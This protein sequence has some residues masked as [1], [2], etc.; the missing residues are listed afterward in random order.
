MAWEL[1]GLCMEKEIMQ[2]RAIR[3]VRC[4]CLHGEWVRSRGRMH[5]ACMEE[6]DSHARKK[7]SGPRVKGSRPAAVGP[8]LLGLGFAAALT[9]P[10]DLDL[11]LTGLI[12]EGVGPW[13]WVR[14]KITT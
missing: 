13:A 10:A 12:L 5:E 4:G 7:L 2:G 14:Q 8:E 1:L 6:E 11:G 3:D 9:R